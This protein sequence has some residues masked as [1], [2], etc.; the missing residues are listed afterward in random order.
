MLSDWYRSLQLPISVD[1]YHQLPRNAAYKYEYLGEY[2]LLSPRPKT[3]NALLDLTQEMPA[4]N[5]IAPS[6]PVTFRG[7]RAEDWAEFTPLFAGAFQRVQ[8]FASLADNERLEAS[9]ACLEQ[10]RTGGDGPLIET[11]CIVAEGEGRIIG[12][13]LNTLIPRR[14]VGEWWDGT[15]PTPL[16]ADAWATG[17]P[18]LTWVFVSPWHAGEGL[19]NELLA[20]A[21]KVLRCAGFTELAS[22]FLLGNESSTL[23]HWR[24]GFRLMPYPASLRKT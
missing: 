13:I 22:T 17:R 15:W 8:P 9:L 5:F 24:N 1:L 19:G 18:H 6:G 12:A 23:W 14:E 3:Y 20:R 7:L 21:V 16:P 4:R 2:A 10:T 11:T